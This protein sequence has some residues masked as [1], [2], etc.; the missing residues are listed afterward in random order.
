MSAWL[1][2]LVALALL[3]PLSGAAWLA[4]GRGV[5]RAALRWALPAASL[6]AL[7]LALV[8]AGALQVDWLLLGT[9]LETGGFANALLLLIGVAWTLAARYAADRVGERPARFGVFWLLSLA[10]I[11]LATLAGDLASFYLGYALMTLSA[12]GLVVHEGGERARF[13]GRVYLVMAVLAEAAVLAGVL[14]VA[15]AYGAVPLSALAQAPPLA[16]DASQLA[17][18]LLLLGFSVKIG[19]AGLHLWLPVAHPVAPVPASAVL[20]GVIVKAGVLGVLRLVPTESLPLAATPWLL[21]LGLFTAFYGVVAGLAQ[22]KLKTVLA[23][24]T[25]SQMGLLFAA[26]ALALAAPVR[27]AAL[28]MLGLLVLHHGLNKAALF[29]AAGGGPLNGPLRTV[30]F[31]LPALALAALPLSSGALAKAGLKAGLYEGGFDGVLIVLSLTSTA[32]ACLLWHA[33][34]LARA[35]ATAPSPVHPAWALMVIAG[36]AVPWAWSMVHA[37]VEWPTLAD[38]VDGLWPLLVAAALVMASARIA[39]ARPG[40][41]WVGRIPEGDLLAPVVRTAS[42]L[43]RLA[44]EARPR[45][46]APRA[47]HIAP[48]LATWIASGER[49]LGSVPAA[50]MSLLGLGI[51]LW[52]IWSD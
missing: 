16:T 45:L 51:A 39:R 48:R 14:L 15:S 37:R 12:Y 5:T 33:W 10:G 18:W 2:A 3:A 47:P 35:T 13:A 41:R 25:V 29:L 6:P 27:E 50:G 17:P 52:W 20:S 42:V 34:R 1:P 46:P 9:R 11:V 8:P 19:V 7:A 4:S 31:A 30:L 22:A 21:S 38:W 26:T 28:P 40:S 36:I 49:A 44:A 32:T 24:S 43:R 23:Y